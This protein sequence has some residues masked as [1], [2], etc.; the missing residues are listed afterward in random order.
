MIILYFE[1]EENDEGEVET[2]LTFEKIMATRNELE[3]VNRVT[4]S[5]SQY[6]QDKLN[7]IIKGES[8]AS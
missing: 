6:L 7:T 5:V 1:V 8:D 3:S 2:D 4:E